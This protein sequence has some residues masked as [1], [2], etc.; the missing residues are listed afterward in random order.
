MY[1]VRRSIHDDAI[2]IYSSSLILL[3]PTVH[4]DYLLRMMCLFLH[5]AIL[6]VTVCVIRIALTWF[7]SN[8]F[9]VDGMNVFAN[10]WICGWI[11]V[12]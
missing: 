1:S 7:K 11:S 6:H 9:C 8:S 12:T 5:I 4:Y 10:S 3:L 2:V